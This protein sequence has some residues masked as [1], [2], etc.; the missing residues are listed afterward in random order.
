MFRGNVKRMDR[1]LSVRLTEILSVGV[2]MSELVKMVSMFF[3]YSM[4]VMMEHHQIKFWWQV[5]I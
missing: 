3:L 1:F 2:T 4:I 5:V